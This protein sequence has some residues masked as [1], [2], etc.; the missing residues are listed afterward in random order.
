MLM[1]CAACRSVSRSAHERRT[2]LRQVSAGAGPFGITP[3]HGCSRTTVGRSARATI[4]SSPWWTGS[5]A[6]RRRSRRCSRGPWCKPGRSACAG[7]GNRRCSSI[8]V[9][10]AA[11]CAAPAT[12]RRARQ[13]SLPLRCPPDYTA[14]QGARFE[15]HFE[16]ARGFYGEESKPFKARLQNGLGRSTTS[17][18]LMTPTACGY[19]GIWHVDPRHS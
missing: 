9:A 10:T 16:K 14:D 2:G 4:S 5:K 19:E 1:L 11:S 17:R 3:G 18:L 7:K 12:G 13:R 8:T 6:S 15:I